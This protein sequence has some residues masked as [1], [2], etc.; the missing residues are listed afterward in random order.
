MCSYF[1]AISTVTVR[2]PFAV[3]PGMDVTPCGEP[4][5]PAVGWGCKFALPALPGRDWA[6]SDFSRWVSDPTLGHLF[7][8]YLPPSQPGRGLG[9][10]AEVKVLLVVGRAPPTENR[11]GLASSAWAHPHARAVGRGLTFILPRPRACERN[12]CSSEPLW[13]FLN[14]L[15]PW[16]VGLTS[17]LST[18]FLLT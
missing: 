10:S 7:H 14:I 4:V 17:S 16:S 6:P 11:G 12:G 3:P 13:G 5:H 1:G 9:T 15:P 8:C 2:T 18:R